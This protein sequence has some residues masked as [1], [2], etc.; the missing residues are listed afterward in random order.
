MVPLEFLV[1]Y[2]MEEAI[3]LLD[4]DDPGIRPVGGGTAIMLMMK[5][6]VL[7]PTRLVSLQ[8]VEPSYAQLA[9]SATGE[10]VIGGLVRLATLEHDAAVK[11]GWPVLARTLR[12]LSSVRVRAVA[13][14]GG[15]LGHAD[16]HMDLPPVLAALVRA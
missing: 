4:A 1:P 16:P 8:H 14:V 5:A 10:L 6:G 2:S 13:T 11:R 9:V 15:A 3:G 12:M 7:S